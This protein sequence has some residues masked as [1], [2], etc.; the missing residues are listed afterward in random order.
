[1]TPK[2]EWFEKDYYADLGVDSGASSEEISKAYRKLA[3]ANHPDANKGDATA[4]E[5]FK[6]VS[7]AYDVLGDAEKRKEYDE[8]R[9][10][11]ASGVGPDGAGGF[12][13]GAGGF[14]GF[15][16]PGFGGAQGADL[17]DIFGQMFGGAGG[18]GGGRGAS[19]GPR[20]GQDLETE[21]T[22][23]FDDAVRGAET[24]VTFT[25]DAA[26][27]VCHGSGAAPGTTPEVCSQCGGSG[28]IAVDQGPFSFSEVC[29]SCG[30]AG[31]IVRDPCS[32]CHGHGVERRPRT[33]KVRI[34]AGVTDG[35]RIRVKGRGAAGSNGGPAGD[36]Y[37]GVH[38]TKHPFFARKGA[39]DLTVT[40]PVTYPEAALGATV[41]VPTMD[42]PVTVKIKAGTASG[43]VQRIRGRGVKPAKGKAG[44]LLARFE[45][46]VP[47]KMPKAQKQ[48]VEALAETITDNPREHLGV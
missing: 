39:K 32:R 12:G 29:P 21:L 10:M 16:G 14:G 33:V 5:R 23:S 26:C 31:R 22:L 7:A 42:D 18:R 13:P 36:L 41:K 11:V 38:V 20:R 9:Q 44:D 24:S 47:R 35:K 8:V 34:P 30:G 45:V 25:A 1:M 27:S 4:E 28:A 48:A 37:V 3:K 40:V 43:T 2:R 15:G 19:A 17:G 6:D 46:A